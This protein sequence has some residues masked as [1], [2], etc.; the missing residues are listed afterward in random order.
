[1]EN[2]AIEGANGAG[3]A[4]VTAVDRA[5]I[6]AEWDK[7]F[8]PQEQERSGL[9][10]AFQEAIARIEATPEH[11]AETK[12]SYR[13]TADAMLQRFAYERYLEPI[14]R[15]ASVLDVPVRLRRGHSCMSVSKTVLAVPHRLR[16]KLAQ[17]I[18]REARMVNPAA[19]RRGDYLWN[20]AALAKALGLV[21][22]QHDDGP[23]A[24]G[25][26]T[27]RGELW[28]P[29]FEDPRDTREMILGLIAASQLARYGL[30][31]TE[32]DHDMLAA[33][34]AMGR[35]FCESSAVQLFPQRF[36]GGWRR[37]LRYLRLGS[38]WYTFRD[39]QAVA[40]TPAPAD[41]DEPS[42]VHARVEIDTSDNDDRGSEVAS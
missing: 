25:R 10:S 13:K 38:N 32:G 9:I 33:E 18:L 3:R 28:I 19:F 12:A 4:E 41:A 26:S 42:R 6:Q 21:V 29:R 24:G 17:A 14:L 16:R 15:R 36:V 30:A 31:F 23:A 22:Y 8:Q 34:L 5:S 1:M 37:H 35:R 2:Q 27:P 11:D 40:A 7:L 20:P 39:R